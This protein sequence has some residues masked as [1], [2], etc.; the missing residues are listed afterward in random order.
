MTFS[1]AS[2]PHTIQLDINHGAGKFYVINPRGDIK[3]IS[4]ADTNLN[5]RVMLT[6]AWN[7]DSVPLKDGLQSETLSEFSHFK[8]YVAGDVDTGA[9]SI[10]AGSIM[11][12]DINGDSVTGLTATIQ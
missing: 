4:W 6:P 12:F 11:G 1:G 7:K 5:L 3:N 8:F 9:L 10:P 2:V